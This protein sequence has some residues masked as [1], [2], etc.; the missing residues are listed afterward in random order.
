METVACSKCQTEILLGISVCG[1]CGYQKVFSQPQ[2]PEGSWFQ[3]FLGE[4]VPSEYRIAIDVTRG[5]ISIYVV[6]RE[7]YRP[8]RRIEK[9]DIWD[10]RHFPKFNRSNLGPGKHIVNEM[11]FEPGYLLSFN[12]SGNSYGKAEITYYPKV[13][14]NS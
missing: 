8:P 13:G 6:K 3:Q 7:V 14:W 4:I 12:D 10:G 9:G 5:P 2:C 11:L 1:K